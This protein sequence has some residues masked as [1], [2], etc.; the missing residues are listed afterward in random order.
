MSKI[1]IGGLDSYG[2]EPF[3]QQQL[4]R[5]GVEGVNEQTSCHRRLRISVSQWV[6][7]GRHD[8]F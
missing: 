8:L 2:G 7:H 5:A 3:E 1:K 4:G 6:V